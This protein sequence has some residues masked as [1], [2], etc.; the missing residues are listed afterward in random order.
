MEVRKGEKLMDRLEQSWYEEG[1]E[2]GELKGFE[3]LSLELFA[4]SYVEMKRNIYEREFM[5]L[6][7]KE[8]LLYT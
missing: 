2:V 3:G 6:T 5:A 1:Y 4:D 7:E 8:R